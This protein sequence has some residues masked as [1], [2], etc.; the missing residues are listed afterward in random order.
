MDV[1]ELRERLIEDFGSYVRSFIR[2]RDAEIRRRVDEELDGGLL[3][4]EPLIQ[5]NPAFEAGEHIDELVQQGVLHDGCDAVFRAGKSQ[6]NPRG[7]RLRL[8]RHQADA[9]RRARSGESYVLTTGTGSGKSLAYIVPIVDH[10]LRHG[11]GKGIQ[12]IVVY[13]MNALANSQAGELEKFLKEGF[14]EGA[15]PVTFARYTG[16]ESEDQ[17]NRII[18]TPP[19]ILLTNYVMLELILTRPREAKLVQRAEGMRFLVFDEL[20]TYRGRQGADVAMLARRVRDRVGDQ[21]LLCVGTS[22]TM[23]SQGTFQQQQTEVARVA[24]QLFGATVKPENVI[25]ETLRRATKDRN[26]EEPSFRQELTA[27]L[28]EAAARSPSGYD[29]FVA[30]PLSI[31]IESTLGVRWSEESKRLVRAKPRR[32]GGSD[33]AGEALS[34][35]TGVPRPRC[36]AAIKRALL[37]GYATPDPTTGFPVFAFRLHQFISKGD[38]VYASIE[39]EDRRHITFQRQKFVPGDRARRLLPLAFCRECGQEYYVVTR[40]AGEGGSDVFESRELLDNRSEGAGY[41]YVSTT[42]PWPD[43]QAEMLDRVPEDWLDKNENRIRLRDSRE[44]D[45]PIPCSVGPDARP[46]PSGIRCHFIPGVFRFCL[47]CGVSYSSRQRS[48]FGKLTVLGS[49]GRSTATTVLTL[50]AIRR[51]KQDETLP[52]HAKKLLSFTDNRQDASLQAGHFNDFVE[53]GLL[54]SALYLACRRAG[55]LT[56]EVLTERVFEALN[57]PL[58][59]YAVDPDVRYQAKADTERA[60]KDVLGYRLYRDLRRGW[61]VTSPNLEQCGLLEINYHSLAELC[62]NQED[63]EQRYSVRDGDTS[64]GAPK[65][66]LHP[67]L[68]GARPETRIEIAQVLLDYMR[69]ELAIKVDYLNENTQDRL[70]QQS[71]QKLREPWGIDESE[72]LERA[73]VIFPRAR[74]PKERRENVFLSPRG[75]FGQYL[76]RTGTFP[77]WTGGKL[78]SA[79]R[80]TIIEDLLK[81]L[82]VAGLVEI[83]VQEKDEAPGYQVP[84]SAFRWVAGDASTVRLDPLRVPRPPKDGAHANPFFIAFYGGEALDA[85]GLQAREHTAQVASEKRQEREHEFRQ[86]NL[87]ILYCS[88]T[89][90]L[91]VDISELNVVNLRNIPPTPANYAQRSGRAGRSGQPALVFSYCSTSSH[92]DQYFFKRPEAMVHGA[93]APP[94]LDLGNED[95]VKSHIHA[96]WLAETGKDL[97]KS[98]KDILDVQGE[99]PTLAIQDEVRRSMGHGPYVERARQRTARVLTSVDGVLRASDWFTPTWVDDVL[100][101]ALDEFDRSCE[102]WRTLFRAARSQSDLQNRIISDVSRSAP[103]KDEARRLRREAEAQIELLTEVDSLAQ[104]DFYSYRY[105]A[106]E[107]FL[108]GYNFPRLPL[109]AYL[110]GRQLRTPRGKADN[111]LSRPRFLAISEFGPRAIVYHEGSRYIINKVIF[112][113]RESGELS[114]GEAKQCKECGYL[115]PVLTAPGPDRCEYCNAE[116]PMSWRSLFRLQNVSTRRRDRINSDEEERLRMGYDLRTAVRFEHRDGGLRA[117]VAEVFRGDEKLATLTYGHA[118]IIWRINLGWKRRRN[119][120]E[121]GFILDEERGYWAK[122]ELDDEDTEDAMSGSRKRVVPYVED[123]R[124]CLLVRPEQSL[125]LGVMASLQ[126]ALKN[127]IQVEYQLEESELAAEPMPTYADRRL[128]LFYEA[129]EGG[130]G[131]LRRLVDDSD[132]F[133]EVC[134]QA[135]SLL[136]FDPTS[137][138]DLRRAL[139]AREDCEAACYDCLMSYGNQGDHEQLDRAVVREHLSRLSM[140]TVRAAPG[141]VPR[142]DHLQTLLNLADSELERRWLRHVEANNLRLPSAAQKLME[143]CQTRPDFLYEGDRVAIY[144]DGPVHDFPERSKRDLQQEEALLDAGWQ[145]IRFSHQDDWPAKFAQ[146]P[147]I[148]GKSS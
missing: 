1:F 6:A 38:T 40:T 67:A 147:S 52:K 128:L 16:Q 85:V 4:P 96:I 114:T 56:H 110:P 120:E 11:S 101:H 14:P 108:P 32:I 70:R 146:F 47:A 131:V 50:A 23:S 43:Q 53:I 109:S 60:L 88:P 84:A 91:G 100:A 58:S 20:H 118:A 19:D 117:Q 27:R 82:R 12:A 103:D 81:A 51:L 5:L 80:Q 90:E 48:E 13:P 104:S 137:L 138:T 144:V 59:L 69:R 22:A 92:H 143:S 42:D 141:A 98:L 24:S 64:D 61:R 26:L 93:V 63:W 37:T 132:A 102:R 29:A 133:G 119:K 21:N 39:A 30:D 126:A 115:H 122:N 35:F 44:D 139:N 3:W 17:R 89:M 124:N 9:V 78:D 36:E 83:V 31:W 74:Q 71:S 54:R 79:E 97:G 135:L 7:K 49:E 66:G 18:A 145:V 55:G 111:Y 123:R 8:H 112:S 130:A 106:S 107:G 10:V 72:R 127:A 62:G 65:S 142:A 86:A 68:V 121:L 87:P 15:S 129:A 45:L 136:H 125:D 77:D 95:L 105:F 57:L 73:S 134:K 46:A 116:L 148:F 75:S 76:G 25:G 99:I 33:G 41:L 34:A 28:A 2:V 140:A 94:R 113:S